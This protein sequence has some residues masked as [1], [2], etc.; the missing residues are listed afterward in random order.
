MIIQFNIITQIVCCDD[1]LNKT[2][3]VVLAV[4]CILGFCKGKVENV[5]GSLC[6][7]TT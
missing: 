4:V 5:L 2:S 6:P 1:R 7:G 3:P